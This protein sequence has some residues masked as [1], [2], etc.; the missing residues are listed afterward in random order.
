MNPPTYCRNAYDCAQNGMCMHG[1]GFNRLP[2]SQRSAAESSA[3]ASPGSKSATPAAPSGWTPSA[4]QVKAAAQKYHDRIIALA[5]FFLYQ[6]EKGVTVRNFDAA[7]N[8]PNMRSRLPK[9]R[10]SLP[11]G[12]FFHK[13][14]ENS[15]EI[16]GTSG[17]HRRHFIAAGYE[18]PVVDMVRAKFAE[19]GILS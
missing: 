1:C 9:L 7:T 8:D 4:E 11:S 16:S 18:M 19:W 12:T 2:T 3:A 14:E 10:R 5:A 6:G 13:T 17:K 15:H